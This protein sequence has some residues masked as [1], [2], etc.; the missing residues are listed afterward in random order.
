M[1]PLQFDRWGAIRRLGLVLAA[2]IVLAA[3]AAAPADPNGRHDHQNGGQNNGQGRGGG[4]QGWGRG[5]GGPP[6]WNRGG[7]PGGFP[8][9]PSAWDQHR[10]NGY[11]VGGRWYFGPPQRPAYEAP[12]FRPGFTPWR[13]GAYLPPEYQTFE[14]DE[15]W[16]YHL[17]RPPLGYHW[18]QVGDEYLLVSVSTG[19]IFDV[20]TVG[21]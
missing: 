21:P 5:Q 11:W 4:N 9:R 8:S 2:G 3:P 10:Y 7:G 6:A 13:R 1:K 20:V 12:G 17:R 18:V 14:L 16:N 15:Y 19:L